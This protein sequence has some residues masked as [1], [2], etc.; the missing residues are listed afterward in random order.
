MAKANQLVRTV[1]L[2]GE[3]TV[4][5]GGT[6]PLAADGVG[7]ILPQCIPSESLYAYCYHSCDRRECALYLFVNSLN[8]NLWVVTQTLS[9]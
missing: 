2:T 5:Q 4:I 8:K 9:I 1:L 7:C 3:A 6:L